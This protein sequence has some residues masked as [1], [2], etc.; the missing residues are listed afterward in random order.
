[1]YA[2]YVNISD[3]GNGTYV[4]SLPDGKKSTY[5][6]KNGQLDTIIVDMPLGQVVSKRR[7]VKKA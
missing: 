1:V 4:L 2:S 7:V 5:I 6:Y 3:K